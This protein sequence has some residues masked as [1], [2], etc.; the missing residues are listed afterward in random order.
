MSH[1]RGFSFNFFSRSGPSGG[2]NSQPKVQQGSSSQTQQSG[3]GSQGQQVSATQAQQMQGDLQKQQLD[4][5]RQQ[6]EV[7]QKVARGEFSASE[8]QGHL[9][10]L[11]QRQVEINGQIAALQGASGSGGSTGAAAP[12]PTGYSPVDTFDPGPPKG[13]PKTFLDSGGGGSKP[14]VAIGQG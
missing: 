13:L 4:L 3:G 14:G 2:S 7:L 1:I 6:Q 9:Q 5:Q 8:G 12:T 11:S 10:A